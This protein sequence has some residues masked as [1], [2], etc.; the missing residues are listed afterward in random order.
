MHGPWPFSGEIDVLEATRLQTT[1]IGGIHFGGPFEARANL[2][3]SSPCPLATPT[4]AAAAPEPGAAAAGAAAA[5]A[6]TAPA[7]GPDAAS[8]ADDAGAAADGADDSAGAD[9]ALGDASCA[10]TAKP[11]P[12]ELRPLIPVP[13]ASGSI[14]CAACTAGVHTWAVEWVVESV[15]PPVAKLTWLVDG[16]RIMAVSN[17]AWW[18]NRVLGDGTIENR[19][20]E[21]PLAPFDAPFYMILNLAVGGN[22]PGFPPD[23][24]LSAV[25]CGLSCNKRI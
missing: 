11:S 22:F 6:A 14:S 5:A 2:A 13:E 8:E 20:A 25:R 9:S 21:V 3:T 19:G 1:F 17:D 24:A 7:A 18:T 23:G 12:P 10:A 15:E 16:L 4:A